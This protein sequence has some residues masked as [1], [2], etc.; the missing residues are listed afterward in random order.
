[1]P[2]PRLHFDCFS[3]LAG[4]MFLGACLDLGLPL[5]LL[6]DAVA[7][8]G[9]DGV[10]L[11]R[12]EAERGGIRGVRFRVLV[13]GVALEGPDPEQTPHHAGARDPGAH[14]SLA[15]IRHLLASSALDSVV[16]D[17]SLGFVSRLAEVE[18]RIHRVPVDQVHFHELGAVDAMVDLVGA[19]VA[20]AH[21]AP[22]SATCGPINVGTGRVR[23]A[24]GMLPVPAPATAE[25]LRGLPIYGEGEGELLTPTGAVLLAELVDR[26]NG[27]L[28]RLVLEGVGYGLGKRDPTGRPNAFRLLR[29][30]PVVGEGEIVAL[31]CTIDDLP[32]EGLGYLMERLLE[33]RAIDV[34][35]T[36]VQMKKNR[37]GT[38]V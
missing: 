19:A 15:D 24:H 10:T 14:R 3:G 26:G 11:E 9:L 29:G 16:R 37:P 4:D 5:E 8:L 20:W 22:E 1:M 18:A 13:D 33:S 36:A 25:L 35:F 2:G 27:D 31:E 34:F 6:E 38:L 30:G 23:T 12:R 17:R 7:R 28:P 21:F 32:G